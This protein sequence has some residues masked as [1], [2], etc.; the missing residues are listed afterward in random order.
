MRSGSCRPT[1]GGSRAAQHYSHHAGY[2]SCRSHGFSGLDSGLTPNLDTLARQSV[3][4]SR[5]Y[6]QVPLTTPSHANIFTGTYTQ[7]NHVGYM[8]QPLSCGSPLSYPISCTHHGYRTAAICR[9]HDPRLQESSGE[10]I[11]PRIRYVRRP[12]S[13]SRQGRRPISECRSAGPEAVVDHALNWLSHAGTKPFFM[14]VHCYDPHAPYDPP[15]PYRTRY[16][17][18]P[19]MVRSLT[20]TRIGRNCFPALRGAQLYDNAMIAVMADHGEA[21][22]EHGEHHHGIFLY[23]ETIHVPLLFKL[24]GERF[25]GKR[26]DVRVRLVDVAP[27]SEGCVGLYHCDAGKIAAG[28][29][30]T[31]RSEKHSRWRAESPPKRKA[32]MRTVL[33]M[34]PAAGVAHGKYLFVER[35][36]V[37]STIRPR[38]LER[39]TTWLPKTQA[40]ADTM[41]PAGS[42]SRKTASAADAKADIGDRGSRKSQGA[43]IRR[44]GFQRTAEGRRRRGA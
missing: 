42:V 25:A 33:S 37:N 15:E 3:V 7:Y 35:R 44:D 4:F 41:Q 22:G 18:E 39:C 27:T 23:D 8:G 5:A 26:A 32:S 19:M 6:A 14:W 16:A 20:P 13:Q 21:L 31:H 36:S 1:L 10:R 17:S 29:M 24:P 28:L 11:R 2:D 12:V 30:E 43:G 40:V 38:I 34:E 9:I